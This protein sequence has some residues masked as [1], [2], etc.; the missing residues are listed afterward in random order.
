MDYTSG[1]SLHFDLTVAQHLPLRGGFVGVGA[2]AFY[3]RQISGDSGTDALLGDFEGQ[4]I[5]V[6]PVLF[7]VRPI[8]GG[9]S[10]LLAELKWLPE[11][12][13]DRRM[14]GDFIWFKL[15]VLF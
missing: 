2:N 14:K 9:K 11:L 6:G 5:G 12:D 8:N 15:G 3:Y 4:T 7:Y 13:V 10:Q 1:S